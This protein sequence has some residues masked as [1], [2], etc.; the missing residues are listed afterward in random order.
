MNTT[1]ATTEELAAFNNLAQSIAR[2]GE[3]RSTC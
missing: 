1:V 2:L 3:L